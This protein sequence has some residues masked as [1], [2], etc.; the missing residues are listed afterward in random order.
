MFAF[1]R[2][3]KLTESQV[4]DFCRLHPG[5][6][7]IQPNYIKVYLGDVDV[8]TTTYV[9]TQKMSATDALELILNQTATERHHQIYIV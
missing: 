9:K 4:D 7:N 3:P 2:K 6:L 5:R 1:N 8:M